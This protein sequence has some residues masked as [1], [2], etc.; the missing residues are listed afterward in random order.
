MK[1]TNCNSETNNP[2]FCSNS[3]SASYNNKLKSKRKLKNILCKECGNAIDRKGFRDRRLI[4]EA[5]KAKLLNPSL[6]DAIYK[7]HHRSSAFALVR[8]R[9][10]S[11]SKKAGMGAC[12]ICGYDKHVE[13]C[14]KI[15]ISL[16]DLN[17]KI[18]EIN[19]LANLVALCP[20]HHWEF[21]NG[22]VDL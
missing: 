4:C 20:N 8:T 16:F 14:H 3:C 1:C 11:V 12:A 7:K 9:A 18:S 21:D 6:G 17:V 5:C 2:K 10:R 22:L 15:P 13:I 19:S